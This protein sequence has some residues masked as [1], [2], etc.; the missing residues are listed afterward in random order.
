MSCQSI[1]RHYTYVEHVKYRAFPLSP[2][3]RRRPPPSFLSSSSRLQRRMVMGQDHALL[4]CA[5]NLRCAN[6]PDPVLPF[7]KKT[8]SAS[9]D[10]V[11]IN[12]IMQPVRERVTVERVERVERGAALP[13]PGLLLIQPTTPLK[14]APPRV[15][16]P[17]LASENDKL[18]HLNGNSNLASG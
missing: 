11:K 2:D 10:L 6:R 18:G 14:S 9:C 8:K 1:V 17:F 4:M 5:F 15:I 3:C 16:Y 7:W 13:H 12:D